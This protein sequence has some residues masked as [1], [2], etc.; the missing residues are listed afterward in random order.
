M[1]T[2]DTLFDADNRHEEAQNLT[3]EQINDYYGF[4]GTVERR[5][6]VENIARMFG[7]DFDEDTHDEWSSDQ[8]HTEEMMREGIL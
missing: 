1:N 7:D 4:D 6:Q 5:N 8:T 3:I 2:Y